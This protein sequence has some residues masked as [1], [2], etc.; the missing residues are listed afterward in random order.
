[1]TDLVDIV[2][3]SGTPKATKVAQVKRRP[4]Y[5]PAFDFYKTLRDH[6][7]AV[8]ADD[9]GKRDIGKVIGGLV[10]GKK[11][12]NY[13]AL[14]AGYIKWWGRKT[15]VWFDPPRVSYEANEVEVIINPELGLQ[16]GG[17]RC[18]IIPFRKIK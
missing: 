8:H 16:F 4:E 17:S 18:I 7:V 12:R 11:L 14:I 13:P 6:I 15:F 10:D 1:M 9:T 3:R 2:S 5:E